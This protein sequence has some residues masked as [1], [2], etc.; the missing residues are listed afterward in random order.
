MMLAQVSAYFQPGP[1]L[2]LMPQLSSEFY[3]GQ[4]MLHTLIVAWLPGSN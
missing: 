4:S 3:G 2:W 1:R